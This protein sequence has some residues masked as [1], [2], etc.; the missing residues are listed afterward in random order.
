M[1]GSIDDT[2]KHYKNIKARFEAMKSDYG[3][4]VPDMDIVIGKNEEGKE[5]IFM[6]VDKIEGKDLDELERLPADAKIKFESFYVR[7]LQSIFDGYKQQKPFYRDIK[8]ENIMYGHKSKEKGAE[9]NFFLT[10]VGGG[11]QDGNFIEFH[12]QF[13]E[14]D[15]SEAFF[16]SITNA[17]ADLKEYAKKFGNDIVLSNIEAKLREIY[18]FCKN[19]KQKELRAFFA[20][21]PDAEKE[22]E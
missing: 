5:C 14:V 13:I 8:T 17:R 21:D 16:R 9:D 3:V 1:V 7:F 6:V 2:I 18:E 19:N 4:N 15:Y 22:F 10:D 11:F 20:R 12:G